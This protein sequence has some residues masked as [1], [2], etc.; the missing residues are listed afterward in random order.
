M[1]SSLSQWSGGYL[2]MILSMYYDSFSF[3]FSWSAFSSSF[4]SSS[5]YS[6]L[7][8]SFLSTTC[9]FLRGRF[10]NIFIHCIC[11]V[12]SCCRIQWKH[13]LA[14][15]VHCHEDCKRKSSSA[16][17]QVFPRNASKRRGKSGISIWIDNVW[18]SMLADSSSTKYIITLFCCRH[19]LAVYEHNS[20]RQHFQDDQYVIVL[21]IN[22]EW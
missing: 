2:V 11:C 7:I 8:I 13:A 6:V 1:N 15:S 16:E 14:H 9:S 19:I 18:Q 20:F 17:S 22:S 4:S 12:R 3:S 21:G 5:S 10:L